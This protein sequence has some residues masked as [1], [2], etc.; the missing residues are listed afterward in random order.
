MYRARYASFRPITVYM[1]VTIAYVSVAIIPSGLV[2]LWCSTIIV[3]RQHGV[4][5][6][7]NN[8]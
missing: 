1:H 7:D 4:L 2:F 5:L 6:A 8:C 3:L